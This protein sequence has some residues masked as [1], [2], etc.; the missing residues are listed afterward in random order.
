MKRTI[1]DNVPLDKNN[2]R[3]V[4]FSVIDA[5]IGCGKPLSFNGTG[6]LIDLDIVSIGLLT[7]IPLEPGNI[8]KFDHGGINKMGV[9]MWSV[10]SSN[11]FRVQVRFL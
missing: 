10:E 3:E 6:T 11:N 5:D 9:V 7:E 8:V 4:K 2:P 1:K